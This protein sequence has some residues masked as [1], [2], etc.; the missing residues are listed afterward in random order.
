MSRIVYYDSNGNE[1]FDN[2]DER[3][4]LYSD[5]EAK[6][7]F[8]PAKPITNADRIRSMGDIELGNFLSGLSYG[9]VNCPMYLYEET[10]TDCGTHCNSS[11]QKWLKQECES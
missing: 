9:C 11:W 7:I 8:S 1:V 10:D 3:I 6:N 4:V 2:G 5:S